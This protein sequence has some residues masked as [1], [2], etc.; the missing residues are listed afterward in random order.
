MDAIETE[1][2]EQNGSTYRITIY[3]DRRHA[4]PARRLERNGH[5]S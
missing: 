3:P 4:Q 1:T 2:V 5:A